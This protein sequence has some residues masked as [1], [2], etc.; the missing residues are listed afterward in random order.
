MSELKFGASFQLGCSQFGPLGA[1]PKD[2][3]YVV[4]G[5]ESGSTTP[6]YQVWRLIQATTTAKE[7]KWIPVK[8]ATTDPVKYGDTFFLYNVS[9]AVELY[10][11]DDKTKSGFDGADG[12]FGFTKVD[13]ACVFSFGGHP[14]GGT[15][16]FGDSGLKLNVI[17]APWGATNKKLTV[18]PFNN[19]DY[20]VWDSPKYAEPEFSI[21]RVS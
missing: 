18:Y 4:L 5:S 16:Q 17:Y 15:V 7:D 8:P 9:A 11:S 13:D 1:Y 2:P 21:D 12:Y 19:W 6:V 14:E 10:V 3:T 20:L